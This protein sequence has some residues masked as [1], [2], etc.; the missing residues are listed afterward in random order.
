[1]ELVCVCLLFVVILVSKDV[2]RFVEGHAGPLPP[3][4]PP[5]PPRPPRPVAAAPPQPA[6]APVAYRWQLRALRWW[7]WKTPCGFLFFFFFLSLWLLTPG[8]WRGGERAKVGG[9]R[10]AGWTQLIWACEPG[11]RNPCPWVSSLLIARPEPCTQPSTI[12][13][14]V[15][16]AMPER[17]TCSGPATGL[18]G[19]IASSAIH[20]LG[21]GDPAGVSNPGQ[22]SHGGKEGGS[23]ITAGG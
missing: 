15:P 17:E 1:M 10:E 12:V 3:P 19:P 14:H 18:L 23:L 22:G 2:H 7:G 11:W 4:A 8:S 9:G 16:P 21:I 13:P 5:H 20:H 6:L